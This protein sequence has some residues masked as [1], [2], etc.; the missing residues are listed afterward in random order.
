MDWPSLVH[1][2]WQDGPAMPPAD[3]NVRLAYDYLRGFLH[4]VTNEAAWTGHNRLRLL[5]DIAV[6][7]L[8]EF[9]VGVEDA[10]ALLW[11]SVNQWCEPLL[12][13]TSL[14]GLVKQ[15]AAAAG[16]AGTPKDATPQPRPLSL[17]SEKKAACAFAAPV[18]CS[19]LQDNSEQQPQLWH[20]CIARGGVTIL[21]ALWK[22]G[23]TTLIAHLLKACHNAG[24]FCGRLVQP[25]RVLYV[26]EESDKRWA[27]RRDAL[28]LGDWIDF[29]V[30]PFLAKPRPHEWAAFLDHLAAVLTNKPADLV[31]FDTISNLWPVRDEN[32]AGEVQAA[33]MPLHRLTTKAAILLVHHLRKG[34]GSEATGLRGSGALPAFADTILEVRRF[35][36]T[37]R[38]DRR[39]VLTGYGRDDDTPLQMVLELREDGSGYDATGDVMQARQDELRARILKILPAEAPGWDYD[40][41]RANWPTPPPPGRQALLAALRH[42]TQANAWVRLGAG[43]KGSPHTFHLPGQECG[44]GSGPIGVE[45]KPNGDDTDEGLGVIDPDDTPFDGS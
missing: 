8:D 16:L 5:S 4:E 45:P 14:R 6:E 19:Q 32:D 2:T 9:G 41:I 15:A 35:D 42:G 43:T 28:G 23:K 18:P 34:D 38:H 22:A 29:Q 3:D 27:A 36:A 40:A 10:T 33:L 12:H 11:H 25:A 39:R 24:T 7:L 37:Q 17:P 21:A 13:A 26:T 1:E 31:V 30:R 44:F 20:G